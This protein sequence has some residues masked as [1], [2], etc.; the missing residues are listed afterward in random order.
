M[1]GTYAKIVNFYSLIFHKS[2]FI[3]SGNVN[4][5]N[6]SNKSIIFS[7]YFKVTEGTANLTPRDSW[8]CMDPY[9]AMSLLMSWYYSTRPS[10]PTILSRYPLCSTIL[11]QRYWVYLDTQSPKFEIMQNLVIR[12]EFSTNIK[13]VSKHQWKSLGI[14][15]IG[16]FSLSHTH[17]WHA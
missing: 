12:L 6:T 8:K 2:T 3:Q 16:Q 17:I 9:S 1:Y 10:V 5:I 11:I 7:C 15:S 13:I 4:S 14:K